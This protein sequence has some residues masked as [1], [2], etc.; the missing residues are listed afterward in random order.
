MYLGN[1]ELISIL[2]NQ[3]HIVKESRRVMI[4]FPI[5][6]VWSGLIASESVE[7][8]SQCV[9]IFILTLVS[10]EQIL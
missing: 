6:S 9:T 4:Y 3:D 7:T 1:A 10:E 2:T 5:D 8:E